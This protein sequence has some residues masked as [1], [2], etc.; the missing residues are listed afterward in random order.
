MNDYPEVVA[1]IASDYLERV[2]SQLRLVPARE[3]D[4]FL[5]ELQSHLYE[6]YQ[7]TPGEDDVARI[8]TV[9]RKLGEPAEV[10]CDRLPGAMVR[11]GARRNLPLYVVGGIL[12]ALFGIPLGFG[13]VAVLVGILFTLAG[14][15]ATYFATVGIVLLT[16]AFFLLLGLTRIY[17][18]EL[19]DRLVT[20]G[21]IQMEWRLA[22]FLDQLSPSA[23]GSLMI[24]F[25]CVFAAIGLG[26]LWLGRYLI[27]GLRFL[28]SLVFDWLRQV[29]QTLRRKLHQEKNEGLPVSEVSFLT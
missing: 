14:I 7:Q 15:A 11:S 5:R 23:Q 8:L 9:L 25:S 22:E 16:G 6:A 13:G 28:F 19:W 24:V 17:Q 12:I 29:A 20:L 21:V 10:V 3:Q 27:R 26:M 2:K 4:E 1:K 18:P